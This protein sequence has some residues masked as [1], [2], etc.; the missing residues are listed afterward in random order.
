MNDSTSTKT[1]M[2]IVKKKNDGGKPA[3]PTPCPGA[4]EILGH[5]G[6]SADEQG[7]LEVKKIIITKS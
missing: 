1:Y 6:W 5:K 2:I 3:S 4:T 7:L